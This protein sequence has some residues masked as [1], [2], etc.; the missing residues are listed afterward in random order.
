MLFQLNGFNA[1]GHMGIV[2]NFYS[3]LCNHFAWSG[4]GETI[5][6]VQ[7]IGCTYGA[8]LLFRMDMTEGQ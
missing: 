5:P 6:L 8:V 2:L 1:D 3:L 4:A 7:P